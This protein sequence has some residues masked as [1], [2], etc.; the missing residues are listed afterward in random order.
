MPE[1][2]HPKHFVVAP[3]RLSEVV[4][5]QIF[6]YEEVAVKGSFLPIQT[7]LLEPW[8][9][10]VSAAPFANADFLAMVMV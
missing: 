4:V 6:S 1:G 7:N 10:M 5:Q 9:I 8:R 3:S 2:D